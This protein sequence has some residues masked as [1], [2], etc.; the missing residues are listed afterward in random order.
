MATLTFHR[1]RSTWLAY[2]LLAFY[3]YFLNILGPITPFLKDEL[4]LS[5]T[6]SSLHFTAFAVGILFVGLGGQTLIQRIG[7]RN[8]LWIGA[9][10]ISISALV[11]LAGQTPVV[12]IGASFFMGLIGSLILVIVPSFLSDQHGEQRAVAFSEANVIASLVSTAAPLMVGWFA[13]LPGG[14]P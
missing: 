14:W 8:S 4:R 11:L 1:D 7:R 3:G 12:T 5:Y 13:H 2:I 10:G 6:V 9:F